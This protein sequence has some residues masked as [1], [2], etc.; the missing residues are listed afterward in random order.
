MSP[1]KSK[2]EVGRSRFRYR[3]HHRSALNIVV[4]RLWLA[5]EAD[6]PHMVVVNP[7]NAQK[8]IKKP[9]LP[10]G[11][12][13][14]LLYSLL[15]SKQLRLLL[16]ALNA[17]DLKLTQLPYHLFGSNAFK[18][19]MGATPWK[20]EM[21]STDSYGSNIFRENNLVHSSFSADMIHQA[22]TPPNVIWQ[23]LNLSIYLICS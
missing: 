2:N 12:S 14:L 1:S 23:S 7:R 10:R 4:K 9:W 22:Y 20:V 11:F 13:I 16:H 19:G 18:W 21:D 6:I 3:L 17:T 8:S 5:E 15:K